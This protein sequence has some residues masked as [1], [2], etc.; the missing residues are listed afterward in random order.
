MIQ[1]DNFTFKNDNH[2]TVIYAFL[3]VKKSS[4]KERQLTPFLQMRKRYSEI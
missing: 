1:S 4:T 2:F 3:A